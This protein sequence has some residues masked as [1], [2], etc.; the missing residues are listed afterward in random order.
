M[1]LMLRDKMGGAKKEPKLTGV[2]GNVKH[3]LGIAN[4]GKLFHID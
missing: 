1:L 2:H 3:V 4:Y